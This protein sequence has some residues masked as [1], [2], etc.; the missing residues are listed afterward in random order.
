M[1]LGKSKKTR[2]FGG[3]RADRTRPDDSPPG[4]ARHFYETLRQAQCER[5]FVLAETGAIERK[6]GPKS[7]NEPRGPADLRQRWICHHQKRLCSRPPA[8]S[9]QNQ[10]LHQRKSM[11]DSMLPLSKAGPDTSSPHPA[12]AGLPELPFGKNR[13]RSTPRLQPGRSRIQPGKIDKP[14]GSNEHMRNV[15]RQFITTWQINQRPNTLRSRLQSPHSSF[16]DHNKPF[17]FEGVQK[18]IRTLAVMSG[19]QAPL[20]H[21]RYLRAQPQEHLRQNQSCGV[22]ANHQQMRQFSGVFEDSVRRKKVDSVQPGNSRNDRG[23]AQRQ[24]E[25]L[26]AYSCLSH[27]QAGSV[28]KTAGAGD[29]L[30]AESRKA[31]MTI[32]WRPQIGHLPGALLHCLDADFGLYI[33]ESKRTGI[34]HCMCP[35]RTRLK[36][37]Q[38]EGP[39]HPIARLGRATIDENHAG[40]Q[41]P[42]VLRQSNPQ[43]SRTDNA[44][45]RS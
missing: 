6:S 41:P 28:D 44:Q 42:A 3:A 13:R 36:R 10:V 2:H 25:C 14:A 30:N 1:L 45:I 23:F 4:I 22:T 20:R 18:D 38:P 29:N 39:L 12:I 40:A 34:T 5:G 37:C 27:L 16:P 26:G 32:K 21:Q 24:D 7:V 8:R 17:L 43:R 35:R 31:L 19:Q 33:G 9:A 11:A 15:Q